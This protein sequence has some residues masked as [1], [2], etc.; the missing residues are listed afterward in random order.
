MDVY[1]CGSCGA[2]WAYLSTICPNCDSVKVIKF[3]E[4]G[5]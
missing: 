1:S 5:K 4:E 2:Q 3:K